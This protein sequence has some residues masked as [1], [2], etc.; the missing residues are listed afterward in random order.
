[1]TNK[2]VLAQDEILDLMARH[3]GFSKLR[4]GDGTAI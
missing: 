2:S 1:M 3:G 4:F